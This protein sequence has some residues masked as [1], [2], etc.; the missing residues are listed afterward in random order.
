MS[1]HFICLLNVEVSLK[2]MSENYFCGML[3]QSNVK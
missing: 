2:V 3:L 1:I